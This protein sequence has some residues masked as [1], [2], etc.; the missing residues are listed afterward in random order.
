MVISSRTPEGEPNRC[1]ICGAVIK[2]E[3]SVPPGDAPCPDCGHLVWF[4]EEGPDDHVLGFSGQ[5]VTAG[6]V[7]YLVEALGDRPFR[8]L[9]LDL[10]GVRFISSGALAAMIELKK[11]VGERRGK[12]ALRGVHPD[13][14]NV[15]RV[16]RLDL[17][18]EIEA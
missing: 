3:P 10:G 16:T 9:V 5:T 14:Q 15:F 1:P 6:V 4:P 7:R 17:L 8:R 13:L 18:F 11:R 12:F 2:I